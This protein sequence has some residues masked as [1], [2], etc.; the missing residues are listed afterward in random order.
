[1]PPILL[2]GAMLA[3]LLFFLALGVTQIVKEH[4]A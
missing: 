1:M 3:P 2:L 4:F